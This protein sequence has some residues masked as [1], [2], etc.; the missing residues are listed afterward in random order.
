[1]GKLLCL[2]CGKCVNLEQNSISSPL[3]GKIYL[4]THHI[5]YML[6]M[7][8][9]LLENSYKFHAKEEKCV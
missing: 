6:D 4:G 1:M 3:N 5:T 8:K 2:Q 7:E 9:A